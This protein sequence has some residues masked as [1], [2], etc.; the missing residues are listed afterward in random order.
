MRS[1]N[2]QSIEKALSAILRPK[3]HVVLIHSNVFSFGR[4]KNPAESIL[5]VIL[6]VVG[7]KR[8]LLMPTFTLSFCKS[9]W[10]HHA[11]T[12][13]ETGALTEVFRKRPGVKRTPC[14]LN[15]FAV[16]GPRAAEF[17]KGAESKTIW[18][19]D[20]IYQALYDANTLVIG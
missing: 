12:P 8:T 5:D 13:S 10:F 19:K 2:L 16:R 20:S 6:N 1:A 11:E 3:D 7:E 18:G 14:A 17:L 15:S 4:L 9:G